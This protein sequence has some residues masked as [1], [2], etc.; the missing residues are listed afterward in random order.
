MSDYDILFDQA[1]VW[2]HERDQ[3]QARVHELEQKLLAGSSN[4]IVARLELELGKKERQI[5]ILQHENEKL[6]A[7]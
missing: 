1:V 4:E 6:R 7:K 3:A 2:K 5:I